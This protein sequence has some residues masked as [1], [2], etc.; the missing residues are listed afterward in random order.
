MK[1]KILVVDDSVTARLLQATLLARLSFD[2]VTAND[3]LD[4]LAKVEAARPDAIL[5]DMM[6]PGLDGVA[7]CLRLRQLACTEATPILLVT[8]CGDA[9]TMEAAFAAGVTDFVTKPIVAAEL[10]SKLRA[11]LGVGPVDVSSE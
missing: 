11:H 9:A 6:M 1:K 4:A 7:T 5:L 10:L 8:T 3:G 2:V